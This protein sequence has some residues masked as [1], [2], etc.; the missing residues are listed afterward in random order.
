MLEIYRKL[1]PGEPPTVDSAETLI[2]P[3]SSLTP[4]AMTLSTVGRYKFNTKSSP[5][6][7]NSGLVSCM[8]A[9]GPRLATGELLHEPGPRPHQDGG[10]GDG[11]HWRHEVVW[12]VDGSPMRIFSNH[13]VDLG[14]LRVI[15]TPGRVRHQGTGPLQRLQEL[16]EQYQGRGAEGRPA[17]PRGRPLPKHIIVEISRSINYMKRS[18]T[19]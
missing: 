17:P 11:R 18:P 9:G 16:L 5:V 13:N 15:L 7:Q 19:I 10:Q 8:E 3:T 6:G 12:E 2:Q 14:R 1:R 4:A